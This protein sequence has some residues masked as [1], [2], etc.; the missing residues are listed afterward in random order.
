VVSGG[1]EEKKEPVTAPK[2]EPDEPKAVKTKFPIIYLNYTC[3]KKG[4]R[5][6]SHGAAL[7][8]LANVREFVHKYDSSDIP[9][10]ILLFSSKFWHGLT[11]IEIEEVRRWYTYVSSTGNFK[12][13]LKLKSFK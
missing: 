7:E 4:P 8:S 6:E 12:L 11:K 2:N 10:G 9:K 5:V 3:Q 13:P 1:E